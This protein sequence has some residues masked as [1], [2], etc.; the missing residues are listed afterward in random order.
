MCTD[1]PSASK[2]Y[3]F[4]RDN[5]VERTSLRGTELGVTKNDHDARG[6]LSSLPDY[7]MRLADQHDASPEECPFCAFE[8]DSDSAAYLTDDGTEPFVSTSQVHESCWDQ[9]WILTYNPSGWHTV[10][11]LVLSRGHRPT[12]A[13]V[14][15][16]TEWLPMALS[17]W[18]RHGD[19]LER[20]EDGPETDALH[21]GVVANLRAGQSVT[22]GHVH[23]YTSVHDRQTYADARKAVLS[24]GTAKQSVHASLVPF[25]LPRV[26]VQIDPDGGATRETTVAAFGEVC[27]TACVET[28]ADLCGVAPPA[29][30][31]WFYEPV[32]ATYEVVYQPMQRA[33]SMEAFYAGRFH[34]F[35]ASD[36]VDAIKPILSRHLDLP[37][38]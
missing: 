16:A 34:K 15:T 6:Y 32:D 37:V 18:S 33:G 5:I 28:F 31:G 35:D 14:G 4:V 1:F 24:T 21:H 25:D 13:L 29:T 19:A 27:A 23:C 12:D 17:R 8:L 30:I 7:L 26:I 2:R 20:R 10:N 22:H 3:R 38:P 11:E 9:G 36:L